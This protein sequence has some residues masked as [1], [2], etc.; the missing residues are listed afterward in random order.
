M[1]VFQYSSEQI[2][3]PKEVHARHQRLTSDIRFLLKNVD[4]W[5]AEYPNRWIAVYNGELVA[6]A[7]TQE[8]I[9]TA[10]SDKGLPLPEVIIDFLGEQQY[11]YIL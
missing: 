7:D 5:R 8:R 11:A 6:V 4:R 1:P 3:E 9:L 2:G 10:I